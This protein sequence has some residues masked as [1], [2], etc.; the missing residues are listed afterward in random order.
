M[1]RWKLSNTLPNNQQVKEEIKREIKKDLETNEKG[2]TTYK[3]PMGCSKSNSKRE[4]DSKMP[5]L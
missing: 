1:N 4:V 5:T 3:K 2:D